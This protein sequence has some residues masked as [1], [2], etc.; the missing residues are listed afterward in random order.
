M[1]K[2]L[3][4]LHDVDPAVRT[5]AQ[6]DLKD[7]GVTERQLEFAS[8]LKH[9]DRFE[10]VRLTGMLSKATAALRKELVL[11]LLHDQDVSVRTATFNQ[12]TPKDID[13]D[14]METLQARAKSETDQTLKNRVVR[15]LAE[16]E[17]RAESVKQPKTG[18]TVQRADFRQQVP[19][20]P[21]LNQHTI[22]NQG[23]IDL[24]AESADRRRK[25]LRTNTLRISWEIESRF[26]A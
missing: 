3:T 18:S 6:A 5:T 26:P 24:G 16:I 8:L 11:E 4:D 22:R 13:A 7:L 10:R 12:L 9:P 1:L 25:T 21:T 19:A 15:A 17:A 20:M 23:L 2:L 14:L